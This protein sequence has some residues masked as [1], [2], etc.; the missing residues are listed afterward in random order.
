MYDDGASH[1]KAPTR[2][3]LLLFFHGTRAHDYL[4][5]DFWP[6]PDPSK[7]ALCF[8]LRFN[9]KLRLSKFYDTFA[10]S[11]LRNDRLV[12]GSQVMKSLC[13]FIIYLENFHKGCC[14]SY[15]YIF[16]SVQTHPN[17]LIEKLFV[18]L[19]NKLV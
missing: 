4:L 19:C 5:S 11:H 14:W 16:R 9:T 6:A 7:V 13:W 2:T 1:H 18:Y 15:T 3:V 17:S 10:W 8:F 12:F